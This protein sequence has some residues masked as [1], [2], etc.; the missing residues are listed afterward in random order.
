MSH[1][2]DSSALIALASNR[3]A[4][5]EEVAAW[6]GQAA[7]LAL[8]PI[9]EGA[10]VRYLLRTGQT[11]QRA[12]AILDALAA[13][14][15]VEWWP[16]SLSY[17]KADLSRVIGHKQVTDAYLVSLARANGARLATLDKPLAAL[18]P[19]DTTLIDTA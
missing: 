2:L 14:E 10:L 12:T 17:R 7:G 5:H 18:F 9:T 6:A 8:C 3:H 4:D 19:T 15:R 11:A 16:G 13:S 1:L